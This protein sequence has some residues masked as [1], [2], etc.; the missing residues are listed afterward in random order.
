MLGELGIK[1]I[2]LFTCIYVFHMS[3]HKRIRDS[4]QDRFQV[5]VTQAKCNWNE[6]KKRKHK[7]HCS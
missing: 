7:S 1:G 5:D 4:L 3:H 2:V 6:A